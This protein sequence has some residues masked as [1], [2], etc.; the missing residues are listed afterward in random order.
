[1]RAFDHLGSWR[2]LTPAAALAQGGAN[3][4][5]ACEL[6]GAL[7]FASMDNE[8]KTGVLGR[9]YAYEQKTSPGWTPC[10]WLKDGGRTSMQPAYKMR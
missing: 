9:R 6:E 5:S 7:N 3:K 10:R 2:F 4:L 1:M 8:R